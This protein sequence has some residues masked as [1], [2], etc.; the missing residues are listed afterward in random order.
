MGTVGAVPWT[1]RVHRAPLVDPLARAEVL[2]VPDAAHKH[3]QHLATVVTGAGCLCKRIKTEDGPVVAQRIEGI[4]IGL[5]AA[6][7]EEDHHHEQ[8][9]KDAGEH[10]ADVEA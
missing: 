7:A 4:G 6:R 9:H 3:H 8:A 1:R 2:G 10:P 5:V